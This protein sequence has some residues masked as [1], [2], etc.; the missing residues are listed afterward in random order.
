MEI[1]E[2]VKEFIKDLLVALQNARLYTTAHKKFGQ[3]VDKAYLDMEGVLG[4]RSEVIIGIIG[5][6]F[7]FENEIFF[8]FASMPFAQ[9]VMA[10]FKRNGIE[11]IIFNPSL[12]REELG[13]FISFLVHIQ[14]KSVKINGKE[15]LLTSG[16]ENI[17]V[18]QIGFPVS[19]LEIRKKTQKVDFG[20]YED[21]LK[22]VIEYI[23][24][25]LSGKTIDYLAFKHNIL[26]IRENALSLQKIARLNCMSLRPVTVAAHSVNISLL[27]MNCAGKLGFSKDEIV[28]IAIAALLHDIGRI[29]LSVISKEG[30]YA[31]N[32]CEMGAGLLLKYTHTLGQLPVL[33]SFEHHIRHDLAGYSGLW[34]KYRPHV[35]SELVH[36]CDVYESLSQRR[37]PKNA[38]SPDTIHSLM[39][40]EKGK[41]FNPELLEIFFRATGI[42]P[43]GT[44][45]K[46]SDGRTGIVCDENDADITRPKVEVKDITVNKV[47]DLQDSQELKIEKALNPF[48]EGRDYLVSLEES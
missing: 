22:K 43:V 31:N 5:D 12:R 25:L 36:I 23:E 37:T 10:S 45:V 44:V 27:S 46:L 48:T 47:I 39:M 21:Y 3:S 42:W 20:V 33:V 32:H 15:Y 18:E 41:A 4:E 17:M 6:D 29:Y 28:E 8:E 2:R 7:A 30:S 13:T 16:I 40:K 11:K 9:E 34:F 19:P 24:A 26:S 35:I 14:E 1:A 38:Y